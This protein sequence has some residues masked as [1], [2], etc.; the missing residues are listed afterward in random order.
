M[1]KYFNKTMA[2]VHSVYVKCPTTGRTLDAIRGDDKV[3]CNCPEAMTRGG[4]H[5]VARCVPSTVEQ[6]MVEHGYEDMP[7]TKGGV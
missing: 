7:Y 2:N 4:T 3:I 5:I 1:A 6:W